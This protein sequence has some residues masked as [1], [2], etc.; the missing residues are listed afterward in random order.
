MSKTSKAINKRN[1][2]LKVKSKYILRQ[3][4]DN[5]QYKKKLEIVRY[6]KNIK[7]KL[8][9]KLNDYIIE[10][11][12][13]EIELDIIPVLSRFS[14]DYKFINILN[15]KNKPFYHIY[16]KDQKEEANSNRI[17]RWEVG[18]GES[19][20]N[21]IRIILDYKIK[22]LYQLFKNCKCIKKI[23]F[24]KFNRDDIKN[25]S[26]MFEQCESLEE[27]DISKLKMDNATDM[28]N[29]FCECHELKELNL[30]TI[31][32]NNVTDLSFMFY[33]CHNLKKLDMTNITI[34][35]FEDISTV[36]NK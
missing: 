4:F 13:I 22:S 33:K 31:K 29:M 9:L 12:K 5:I 35:N 14:R 3:I 21:K 23:K 18:E 7:E 25:L 34:K 20:I 1:L 28:S 27:L 36:M 8:D 17:V 30:P 10:Y 6:N 24:T 2:L 11:S 19:K 15:K 16:F 26:Q 32:A